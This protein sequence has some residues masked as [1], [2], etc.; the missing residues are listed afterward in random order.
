MEK[1]EAEEIV[2]LDVLAGYFAAL[3]RNLT[4]AISLPIIGAIV[5]IS[6]FFTSSDVW[7]SSVLIETSLLTPQ[8][9]EFLFS[10][11]ENVR[12]IPGLT[13][14]QQKEIK[15]I[16]YK[17]LEEKTENR[18]NDQSVYLQATARVYNRKIFLVLQEALV[19]LINTSP[20]VVRHRGERMLYYDHL[21]T[22]IE[23]EISAMDSVK[24]QVSGQIQ[25]TYLNPSL[26][27]A[28]TVDLFREKMSLQIKRD[29][30][31]TVHL[32]KE[33]DYLSFDR[34][35]PFLTLAFGGL[36]VGLLLVTVVL[37][38]KFFLAYFSIYQTKQR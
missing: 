4:L 1:N 30:I 21:I 25:A 34:K 19:E 14:E 38:V 9:G 11:L 8:E 29:E 24:S 23:E 10:Q 5:G 28:Q 32:V 12:L 33:F 35:P 31:K 7:E 27:Y 2:L 16:K 13:K 36:V 6:Y 15:K 37:F 22:K 26:L 17:V 20:P 18:L 3:Q